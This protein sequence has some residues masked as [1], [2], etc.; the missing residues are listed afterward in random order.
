MFYNMITLG[1]IQAMRTDTNLC[2]VRVPILEPAG[3]TSK[4]LM[5]ATMLLPPGIHAGYEVGD[6]VFLTFADNSLNR[7]VVLGQ[8][9][10][11]AAL[12]TQIDNLGTK[13]DK[14]DRATSFSCG[15]LDVNGANVYLPTSTKFITYNGTVASG[16]SKTFKA[17]WED[18]KNLQLALQELRKDHNKLQKE[19]DDLKKDHDSLKT[20]V[21]RLNQAVTALQK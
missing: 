15:D 7:P 10:R 1:E 21:N 2:Q 20:T 6:V 8:L 17:L 9:Y 5:W 18:V 3:H 19:H 12:G 13:S 16:D 11:G 4:F 14:L